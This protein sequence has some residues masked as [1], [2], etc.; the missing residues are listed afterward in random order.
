MELHHWN[1]VIGLRG[2]NTIYSSSAKNT[3]SSRGAANMLLA[4][5]AFTEGYV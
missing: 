5:C 1:I 3:R 2:E 4:P